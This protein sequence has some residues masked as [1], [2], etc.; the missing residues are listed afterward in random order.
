MGI[1]YAGCLQMRAVDQKKDEGAV[2]TVGSCN[3][4]AGCI[5]GGVRALGGRRM[6]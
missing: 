5:G 6:G 3:Q 1:G 4:R 2:R